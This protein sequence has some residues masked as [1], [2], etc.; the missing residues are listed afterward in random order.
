M[1]DLEMATAD[2]LLD[3]IEQIA[4]AVH[5]L[6]ELG[7][8]IRV[9]PIAIRFQPSSLLFGENAY[10]SLVSRMITEEYKRRLLEQIGK[11]RARREEREEVAA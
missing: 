11:E 10:G 3:G 9:P 7:K 6:N 8:T 2:R 1:N 4:E 5:R